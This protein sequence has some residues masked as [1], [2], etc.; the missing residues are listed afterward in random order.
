MKILVISDSHRNVAAITTVLK[1]CEGRIDMCVF[2]GDGVDDAEY[3][4]SLF[5]RLPRVIVRGNCDEFR[6]EPSSDHPVETIFE[7]DGTTFLCV[8]GHRHGVKNGTQSAAE[9]AAEKGASVLLYGHTHEKD[10]SVVTTDR[11]E[12]RTINPGSIG[13]GPERSFALVETVGK[14]VVCGF[15]EV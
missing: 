14:N 13:R 12:V 6:F 2:L 4:L 8:H 7:A 11:G 10:D 15:G 5:P 1:R 3:A 9:Y